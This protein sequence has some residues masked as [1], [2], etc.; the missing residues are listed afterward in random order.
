MAVFN[1]RHLCHTLLSFMIILKMFRDVITGTETTTQWTL[2]FYSLISKFTCIV[3]NP[4]RTKL[5]Y[6]LPEHGNKGE[7]WSHNG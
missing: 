5:L 3:I 1:I 4:L 2:D 6:F 7:N